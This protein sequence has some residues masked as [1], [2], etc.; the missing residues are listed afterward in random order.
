M[1]DDPTAH[2]FDWVTARVEC[3]VPN[4]FERLRVLVKTNCLKRRSFLKGDTA[5]NLVFSGDNGDDEFSVT[6]QP[7]PTTHGSSY[8]VKF[9]LRQDHILIVDGWD[10]RCMTLTLTL[11]DEGQCL[12]VIDGKGEHLRWQV[13]RKA[14]HGLFFDGPKGAGQ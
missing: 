4:E 9:S 1:S 8:K 3:S 14:L 11:S 6:R 12:F 5:A 10:E 7:A 13:V 2:D